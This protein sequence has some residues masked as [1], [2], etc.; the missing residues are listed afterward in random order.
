M[1]AN[2]PAGMLPGPPRQAV[3]TAGKKGLVGS[4]CWE[5]LGVQ[6]PCSEGRLLPFCPPAPLDQEL[7]K[8]YLSI[9][10]EKVRVDQA[11][12]ICATW[13]NETGSAMDL[14]DSHPSPTSGQLWCLGQAPEPPRDSFPPVK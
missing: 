10:I 3:P 2:Y 5:P 13:L 12:I 8:L 1:L 7:Q 14:E 4:W 9:F 6:E 11:V